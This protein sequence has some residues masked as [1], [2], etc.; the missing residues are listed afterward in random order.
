MHE[1][2]KNLEFEKASEL[3][4]DIVSIESL[5]QNQIVRDVI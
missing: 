1:F 5:N 4:E 2:A 3:K